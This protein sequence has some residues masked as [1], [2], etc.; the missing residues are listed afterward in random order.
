LPDVASIDEHFDLDL[1]VNDYY[2]AKRVLDA[3][4]TTDQRTADRLGRVQNIFK[5]ADKWVQVDNRQ[6]GDDY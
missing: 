2:A 1:L 5:V 4:S 3:V 6:L